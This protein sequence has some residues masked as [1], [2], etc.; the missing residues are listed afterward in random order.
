MKTMYKTEG[1]IYAMYRGIIPT[2]AGVGPYVRPRIV[3]DEDA[4]LM[5]TSGRL[6]LH[7]LRNHA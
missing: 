2:V 4:G 3:V 1:G 5:L 7:G 6:E